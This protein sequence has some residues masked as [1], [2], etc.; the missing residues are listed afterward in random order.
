[1]I[2]ENENIIETGYATGGLNSVEYCLT[3]KKLYI[4]TIENGLNYR[5][6]LKKYK[7]KKKI[8]EKLKFLRQICN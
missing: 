5:N 4:E 2:I 8:N 1:M 6:N 7:Q 3:N